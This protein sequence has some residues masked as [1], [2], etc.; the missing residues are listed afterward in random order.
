[1]QI[2]KKIFI[3]D[4][5]EHVGEEI[6][7]LFFVKGF[8]KNHNRQ[9]NRWTQVTVCDRSGEVCAKIWSEFESKFDLCEQQ[10][11]EV[12]GKVDLY[13]GMAGIAIS[14]IEVAEDYILE[15][16]S[17]G[18]D[19]DVKD[20]Y[21]LQLKSYIDKI[22]DK[23]LHRLVEA[24]FTQKN[25][26]CMASLP[27]GITHHHAFNGGQLTHTLEVVRMAI[28]ATDIYMQYSSA[29]SYVNTPI[30]MDLL[31]AG[32]LLHDIGKLTEYRS[33]P[34]ASRTVRGRLVGHLAEGVTFVNSYNMLLPQGERVRD[35]TELIHIIEASHGEA[36][37]MLPCTLEAIIVHNADMM[38]SQMDAYYCAFRD[39]DIKHPDSRRKFIASVVLGTKVYRRKEG[40]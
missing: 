8:L 30:D 18:M 2:L 25:Q 24:I 26:S 19:S 34:M 13:N 39:E 36:G 6:T 16:F 40:E 4:L 28:A 9:G 3:E 22:R 21:L 32:A 11:C 20:G 38:S 14:K 23:R 33:F 29:K 10:V 31:V 35:L 12:T 17:Y 7:D 5:I 27:A 37:G 15:D 1:M